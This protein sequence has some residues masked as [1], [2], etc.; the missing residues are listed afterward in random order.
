M[1][2]TSLYLWSEGNISNCNLIT[3]GKILII[4]YYGTLSD[5]IKIINFYSSML[6]KLEI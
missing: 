4:K 5:T 2:E 1:T 3:A 6:I